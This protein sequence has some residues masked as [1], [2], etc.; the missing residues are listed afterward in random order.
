MGASILEA[1]GGSC[2]VTGGVGKGAWPVQMKLLQHLV[3]HVRQRRVLFED[4]VAL[5]E[6]QSQ[7]LGYDSRRTPL[8][9]R[10]TL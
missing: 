9:D 7:R 6:A 10:K 8:R 5:W 4:A 3:V 1:L 2:D